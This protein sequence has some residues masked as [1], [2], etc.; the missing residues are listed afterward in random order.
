MSYVF[1]C[2]ESLYRKSFRSDKIEE[3]FSIPISD[4]S[5]RLEITCYVI[6]NKDLNGISFGFQSDDFD[7]A[8]FD[9]GKGEW[10]GTQQYSCPLYRASI[11][12]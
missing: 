2:A 7:D 3:V 6:S 11:S 12:E 5:G 8:K 10:L 9:V 4:L 1:D